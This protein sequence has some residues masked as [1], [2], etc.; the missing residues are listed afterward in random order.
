MKFG[1]ALSGGATRGAAHIGALKAMAEEGMYPSWISGTSA[2]SMVAALYACG[3][4]A[5]EMEK[6]L[7]L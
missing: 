7:F 3:Y 5:Q 6:L 4:N 2:G 1:L